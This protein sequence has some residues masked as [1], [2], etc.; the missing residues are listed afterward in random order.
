MIFKIFLTFLM[1]VSFCSCNGQNSHANSITTATP[2][3][4]N[5]FDKEVFQLI[6]SDDNT[7]NQQL[8]AKYPQM[9][10][11]LGKGILNMQS[12]DMPGFFTKVKN[13]DSEPT[14]RSLYSGASQ[15]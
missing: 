6:N 8:L 9:T 15:K 12:P 14:L 13:F 4:I 10:E 5:R 11:I 1:T 2:M 3:P 7:L